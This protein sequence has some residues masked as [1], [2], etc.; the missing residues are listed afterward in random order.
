MSPLSMIEGNPLTA[1]PTLIFI[2]LILFYLARHQAH[3]MIRSFTGS[4]HKLSD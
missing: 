4:P 2:L 1:Y 3:R